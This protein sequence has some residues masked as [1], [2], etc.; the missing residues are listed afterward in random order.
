MKELCCINLYCDMYNLSLKFYLKLRGV[1]SDGGQQFCYILSVGSPRSICSRSCCASARPSFTI[2]EITEYFISFCWFLDFGVPIG[3]RIFEWSMT[4]NHEIL[5]WP[6]NF[7]DPDWL[8]NFVGQLK[9]Y[10]ISEYLQ[11]N[12]LL[13]KIIFIIAIKSLCEFFQPQNICEEFPALISQ[14]VNSVQII[15]E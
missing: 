7:S 5:W 11:Y 12:N 10:S 14:L 15:C 9:S 3:S 1:R 13:N 8:W 4:D 2:S 6:Q